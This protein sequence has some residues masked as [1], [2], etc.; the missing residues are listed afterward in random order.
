MHSLNSQWG[1][2]HLLTSVVACFAN[3]MGYT[4]FQSDLQDFPLYAQFK[5]FLETAEKS[6]HR[7]SV[8][9]HR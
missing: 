4:W 9:R 7:N 8:T 1:P 6:F 2:S 3:M 5:G